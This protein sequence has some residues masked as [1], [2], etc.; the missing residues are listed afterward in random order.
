MFSFYRYLYHKNFHQRSVRHFIKNKKGA[1]ALEFAIIF[2]FFIAMCFAVL[3]LFML[4]FP[5]I[6]ARFINFKASR[7]IG[8][9][10]S[11]VPALNNICS[12]HPS[13]AGVN[14]IVSGIPHPLLSNVGIAPFTEGTTDVGGSMVNFSGEQTSGNALVA[15]SSLSGVACRLLGLCGSK[16][17]D[18]SANNTFR[19]VVATPYPYYPCMGGS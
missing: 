7:Y 6:A 1:A 4:L 3:Y 18:F 11:N 2:P 8:S 13:G 14:A 9:G 5:Q 10:S 15:G 17:G 16:L 12:N 19:G